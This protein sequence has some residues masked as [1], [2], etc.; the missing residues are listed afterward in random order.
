MRLLFKFLIIAI[1]L[2]FVSCK[3][4]KKELYDLKIALSSDANSL[5]P[6]HARGFTASYLSMQI[7][8]SLAGI[9]YNSLE[10]VGMVAQNAPIVSKV[11][12]SIWMFEFVLRKDAQ[13]S[14]TMPLKMKDV[15]FS[16]K[17]SNLEGT[18]FP[19]A[20]SYYQFI[21]SLSTSKDTIRFY[22]SSNYFNNKYS[23][24]DFYIL[25][26][27]IYDEE[28]VLSRYSLDQI[29][30]HDETDTILSNFLKNF[31]DIKFD[32]SRIVGS[33]AYEVKKWNEKQNI[34]LAKKDQW[35]GDKVDDK[36][37]YFEAFPKL[38]NYKFIPEKGTQMA[39]FKSGELDLIIGL[40]SR[41]A[42]ELS[43]EGYELKT[44]LKHAYE[45]LGLNCKSPFLS[46]TTNRQ[47]IKALFDRHL[48]FEKVFQS[49]GKVIN[50][51]ILNS[52]FK[53]DEQTKTIEQPKEPV[54]L[55]LLFNSDN[56]NRKS[57]A[58]ILKQEF[59]QHNILIEVISKER[60]EYSKALREGDF[61]MYLGGIQ[62]APIPPDFYSSFHSDNISGGR[63]YT[64]Y[65]SSTIDSILVA[66][67]MSKDES[68]RS[69]LYQIFANQLVEDVPVIFFLQPN[70]TFVISN[71]IKSF[72][73]S[74][75]RPHFWAPS[76]E[77]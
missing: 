52:N 22:S 50:H 1:S 18:S 23:C 61:D 60:G 46:E 33:G 39:A 38:I 24:S 67:Q 76:I 28:D 8:Q 29:R 77:L 36:N 11:N 43:K 7:F 3:P 13:F 31:N 27:L 47:L 44:Q 25:P 55:R 4:E 35:W 42:K 65:Y 21:D 32:K 69:K 17:L 64:N 57:I 19:G 70:E 12:D 15:I 54:S 71:R 14:N 66:I 10:L 2:Q 48:I 6:L 72:K 56:D 20:S 49:D 37:S 74:R 34:L 30:S 51:P 53:I 73:S 5:N 58:L 59:E 9:D 62:T 41:E 68:E 45:F 26:Q 63:N 75:F 40:N 16:F